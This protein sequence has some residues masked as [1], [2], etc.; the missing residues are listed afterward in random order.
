MLT[1]PRWGERRKKYDP[2]FCGVFRAAATV[3]GFHGKGQRNNGTEGLRE[4]STPMSVVQVNLKPAKVA[5]HAP[6]WNSLF[7][8][9]SCIARRSVN[10]TEGEGAF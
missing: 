10:R 4:C 6:P 2:L 1:P 7:R 3:C 5:L 9:C 8:L